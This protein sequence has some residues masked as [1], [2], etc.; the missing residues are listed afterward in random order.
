MVKIE[1]VIKRRVKQKS[2]KKLIKW[3]GSLIFSS[4]GGYLLLTIMVFAIISG[5]CGAIA[6]SQNNSQSQSLSR[7][8]PAAVESYRSLVTEL[9]TEYNIADY[10]DLI[11]AIMAAESG[12]Q[13]TDP[14]QSSE[15]GYNTK[16]PHIPSGITDTRYSIECGVQ[17]IRDCITS[18]NV[19]SKNDIDHI[20]VALQGYNFG[21]GYIL[22][23]QK[24]N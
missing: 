19:E 17:M 8:L 18:A 24:N 13:G 6:N 15:C 11:L 1:S 12:G 21:L 7:K 3:L 2:K 9:A 23:A 4:F 14:M 10:V 22:D 5:V 16:Y 20:K